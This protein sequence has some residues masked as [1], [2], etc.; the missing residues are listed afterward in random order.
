MEKDR[1]IT[2]AEGNGTPPIE[3]E[4]RWLYERHDLQ[5]NRTLTLESSED[6]E[7][8]FESDHLDVIQG[9]DI[10]C[11][12]MLRDDTKDLV[13]S[14]KFKGLPIHKYLCRRF[15]STTRKSLIPC[16]KLEGRQR[17]GWLYSRYFP[18]EAQ[19]KYA[20]LN[21]SSAGWSNKQTK[22]TWQESMGRII[23]KLTLQDASKGAYERGETL[24]GR[25]MELGQLLSFFRDA[26]RGTAGTGGCKSSLFLAGPPGVGKVRRV[27]WITAYWQFYFSTLVCL[28]FFSRPL[29]FDLQLHGYVENK[30][31]EKYLHSILFH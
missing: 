24:I 23:G 13:Q 3:V 15:W 22:L 20:T 7:E 5:G 16:G 2:G 19:E 8:V 10:L 28:L 6:F 14:R 12:A 26:I 25:E 21:A 31:K 30:R 1:Q 18:E 29:V 9:G 17:R 27:S 4:I 11:P